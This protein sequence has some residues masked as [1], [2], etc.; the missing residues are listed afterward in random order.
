MRRAPYAAI[1]AA[2]AAG[3]DVVNDAETG[4]WPC[5]VVT[6]PTLDPGEGEPGRPRIF[7][8]VYTESAA[9]WRAINRYLRRASKDLEKGT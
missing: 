2:R 8:S 4:D 1:H 6:H 9:G 5:Y 3:W 7:E